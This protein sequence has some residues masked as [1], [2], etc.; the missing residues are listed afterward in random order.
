MLLKEDV[1][2]LFSLRYCCCCFSWTE[3]TLC[4]SV[5]HIYTEFFTHIYESLHGNKSQLDPVYPSCTFARH[6]GADILQTWL[7]F[8]LVSQSS[9]GDNDLLSV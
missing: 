6:Q 1:D 5:G 8:K 9:E 7:E 2:S 3:I 4:D